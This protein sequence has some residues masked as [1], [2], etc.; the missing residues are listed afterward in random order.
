MHS[1]RGKNATDRDG[2]VNILHGLADGQVLQRH[3]DQTACARVTGVCSA[4]GP[5]HVRITDGGRVVRGWSK[6][7]VGRAVRGRFVARL[8]GIPTGG[9]YTVTF[10]AGSE[11]LAVR[12]VHVGD[13]WLLAGQSNMQGCG[14]LSGAPA[15]HRLVHAMYMDRHWDV[16]REPIHFPAE[17]PDPVHSDPARSASEIR[18]LRRKTWFGVGP[19]IYFGKEMVRRSGGVPQGLICTAKG[20]TTMESWSPSC[21]NMG[22][23]SLYGS[24]LLSLRRS[25]QPISGVL[26]CQGESDTTRPLAAVYTNAMKRFVAAIRRDL[27]QPTLPFFIA[28]LGRVS[29]PGPMPV[30]WNH[31]QNQQYLLKKHIQNLECV[32]GVDLPLCDI[33]HLSPEGSAILGARLAGVADRI[34]HGNRKE[35]PAPELISVVR[36]RNDPRNSRCRYNLKLTFRNIAGRLRADGRPT[37]FALVDDRHED[38]RCIYH[39]KISGRN[40]IHLEASPGEVHGEYK[41]T[42]NRGE[43]RLIHGHG[44]SPHVN[45]R[46]DRGM[47]IPVFGPMRIESSLALCPFLMEWMVSRLQK[48]GRPLRSLAR[49][50]PSTSFPFQRYS[51]PKWFVDMHEVWNGRPGQCFFFTDIRLDESMKLNLRVGSDGP[52]RIWAGS[53]PVFEDYRAT[54]PAIM[55]QHIRPI[56]LNKGTHRITVAMDLNDGHAWGFYLRFDRRDVSRLRR[57]RGDYAVPVCCLE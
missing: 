36:T 7:R 25:A 53:R 3:G 27:K 15:P 10:S 32:P 31:I 28:Q 45:I 30:H 42:E 55:D 24:M 46:D 4:R 12:R 17:S 48:P 19:G 44:C 11:A 22:A 16:A 6:R 20:G 35:L 43:Y 34:V 8:D 33:I 21:K 2:F 41:V 14:P 56:S 18:V 54:N 50:R 49:P 38:G 9:P 26:W 29:D 57:V 51:F 37:G 5:V 52:I 13:V 1:P 39:A 47:P 23:R 40:T